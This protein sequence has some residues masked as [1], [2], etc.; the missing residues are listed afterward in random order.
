MLFICKLLVCTAG[1][2]AFGTFPRY[3]DSPYKVTSPRSRII[4]AICA[5]LAASAIKQKSLFATDES[6]T[7]CAGPCFCCEDDG[8]GCDVGAG[9]LRPWACCSKY[10]ER[11]FV[12]GDGR[13]AELDIA[14]ACLPVGQEGIVV[15]IV[16]RSTRA[17]AS[18]SSLSAEVI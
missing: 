2:V 13:G 8:C 7:P 18:P 3:Q 5:L 6:C 10:C 1:A 4:T 12:G 16:I 14:E 11:W 9:G 15:R 17:V